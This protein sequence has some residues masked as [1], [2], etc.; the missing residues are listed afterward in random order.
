MKK[1]KARFLLNP[2]DRY[3]L[4]QLIANGN[5][6]HGHFTRPRFWAFTRRQCDHKAARPSKPSCT[7]QDL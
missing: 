1:I 7:A 4:E 2:E 3:G 5:R 6:P